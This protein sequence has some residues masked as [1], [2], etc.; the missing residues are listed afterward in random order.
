MGRTKK[1][2]TSTPTRRVY[3]NTLN[4]KAAMK[5]TEI[6]AWKA[7]SRYNFWMF[8]YHCARWSDINY[9]LPPTKRLK[10]PFKGAET[11]ARK[12]LQKTI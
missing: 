2:F 1:I 7:L 3:Q 11:L 9:M 12:E 8:D 6:R 4:T 10:Y 5:D